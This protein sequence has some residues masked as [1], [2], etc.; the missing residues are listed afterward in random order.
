MYPQLDEV[1]TKPVLTV[2]PAR[3]IEGDEVILNCSSHSS[4]EGQAITGYAWYLP[5]W[6]TPFY[7]SSSVIYYESIQKHHAGN[8]SCT[9]NIHGV[10]SE[11]SDV[12]EV[13]VTGKLCLKSLFILFDTKVYF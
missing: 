5:N 1:A 4:I 6:G 2:K 12:F 3:P 8:Y 9:A 7:S 13:I 11:I 10:A